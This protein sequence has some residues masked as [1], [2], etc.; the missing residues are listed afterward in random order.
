M[1]INHQTQPV[2]NA[3]KG[4][5]TLIPA[6]IQNTENWGLSGGNIDRIMG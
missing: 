3:R 4:A 6:M 1:A 2:V 5:S